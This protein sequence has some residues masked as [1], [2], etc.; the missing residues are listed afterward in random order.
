MPIDYALMEMGTSIGGNMP[1][2]PVLPPISYGEVKL[3]EGTNSAPIVVADG[4]AVLA[5]CANIDVR[6]DLRSAANAASLNPAASAVL[7]AAGVPRFFTLR[8]G[9]WI[10]KTAVY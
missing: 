4:A 3:A 8:K 10:L 5:V 1:P 2:A 7:V 9:S 6:L